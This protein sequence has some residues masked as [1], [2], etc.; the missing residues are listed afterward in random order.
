MIFFF[1]RFFWGGDEC[2]HFMAYVMSKKNNNLQKSADFELAS[3][4]IVRPLTNTQTNENELKS[5][6]EKD[7][8]LKN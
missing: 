3:Q 5:V 2:N 7:Q 4:S 6:F 8:R 1:P